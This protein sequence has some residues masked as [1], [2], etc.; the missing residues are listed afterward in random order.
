MCRG[1]GHTLSRPWRNR[2]TFAPTRETSTYS[3]KMQKF[4]NQSGFIRQQPSDG[5]S[6]ILRIHPPVRSKPGT[7]MRHSQLQAQAPVGGP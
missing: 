2:G 4:L 3:G 1:I 6:S 5:I 7:W